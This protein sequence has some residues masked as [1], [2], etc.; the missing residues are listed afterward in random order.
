MIHD[1]SN[2][3]G[4]TSFADK[5]MFKVTHKKK[6]R[7]TFV[8]NPLMSSMLTLNRYY[9]ID[10]FNRIDINMFEIYNNDIVL[11]FILDFEHYFNAVR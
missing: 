6:T 9:D 11:V 4:C 5:C 3:P 7:K 1:I 2:L 10:I 8:G